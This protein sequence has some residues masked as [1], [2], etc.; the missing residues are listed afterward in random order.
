MSSIRAS[1]PRSPRCQ[2]GRAAVE[3]QSEVIGTQAYALAVMRACLDGVEH[4]LAATR[5]ERVQG[6]GAP[7]AVRRAALPDRAQPLTRIVGVR[8]RRRQLPRP[9]RDR[10][11]RGVLR[12]RDQRWRW[13]G[14]DGSGTVAGGA[15]PR[16]SR[17]RPSAVVGC[18]QPDLGAVGAAEVRL[19]GDVL[20]RQ[21]IAAP[22]ARA[23]RWRWPSSPAGP[24]VDRSASPVPLPV[25]R[26]HRPVAVRRLGRHAVVDLEGGAVRV[27]WPAH[28]LQP[29][30]PPTG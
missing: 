22:V 2:S 26:V 18:A 5:G 4:A 19:L 16:R 6:G 3:E 24:F 8:P 28:D 10:A 27:R 7:A 1:R 30:S 20:Q 15:A 14:A 17:P 13:I 11:Q 9:V 12:V 21:G 29:S 23:S 25:G